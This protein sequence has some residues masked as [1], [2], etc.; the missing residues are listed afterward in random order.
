MKKK[1][2]NKLIIIGV[3]IILISLPFSLF[4]QE[5]ETDVEKFSSAQSSDFSENWAVS[6]RI[7]TLGPGIGII[8]Y[9]SPSFNIRLGAGYFK[10]TYDDKIYDL[11]IDQS[12]VLKLGSVSLLTDWYFAK[13]ASKFHL[14]GGLVY[15]FTELKVTGVPYNA[16]TV[17]GLVIQPDDIGK[18]EIEITPN[19]VNP[20]LSIG[21]GML[22]SQQK[23]VSFN[24]ELG[25]LYMGDPH[26]DMTASEMI[27]PTADQT[28]II[29]DNFKGYNIYPILSFQ[30]CFRIL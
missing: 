17:G 30:L 22:V 6:L 23:V 8:K 2:A 26:V 21:Y 9:L 10:Y 29:E 12:C 16:Y 15:N 14:T 25:A 18:L 11:D 3:L 27:T 20:Y 4:S 7:N 24:V 19:K 5:D 28:E 1:S 13:D